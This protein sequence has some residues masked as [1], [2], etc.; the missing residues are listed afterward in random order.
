MR[1]ADPQDEVY[2][3]K[4]LEATGYVNSKII[5]VTGGSYGDS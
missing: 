5:G 1:Q 2:G 4:F 3:V